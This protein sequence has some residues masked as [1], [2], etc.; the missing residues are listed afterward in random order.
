MRTT[1]KD[2]AKLAGVN[3]TL[4]SK[5]LNHNPQARMTPATRKR[6]DCAI[7]RLHYKPSVIARSLRSGHSHTVGMVCGNLTN[8]YNA[9][10]V[11]LA[12]QIFSRRGYQMLITL[13]G[14]Q[15]T[16]NA[17]E[18]LGSR[19]V[20]G[21]LELG[22]QIPDPIPF[23]GP[24]QGCDNPDLRLHP[25]QLR[26][27]DSLDEALKVLPGRVIG[28]FFQPSCW[29]GA[30]QTAARRA[31]REDVCESRILHLEHGIRRNEIRAVCR[32]RPD[33][34]L[35]S[36]WETMLMLLE[37]L[38]DEFPG[39]HPH[40]LLHAN[41]AVPFL[42]APE[43]SG[44]IRS[45]ARELIRKSCLHLIERIESS[46]EVSTPPPVPTRF[47]PRGSAG[48]EKLITDHFELT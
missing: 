22:R 4:V 38:H 33:S 31:G 16:A 37:L 8:A 27:D 42:N 40:L 32:S 48:Y 24:V 7:Q 23:I 46:C 12:L 13:C 15:N 14:T 45:S 1:L 19:G 11:N 29:R 39:W 21:I 26:T 35:S 10:A 9:H 17:L 6:I 41:C 3:F 20:D 34:I 47:I 44:V 2:V 36:G 18:S 28:L 30:F 43:I 25:I 5:Y